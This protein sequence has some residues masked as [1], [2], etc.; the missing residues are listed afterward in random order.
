MQLKI[1][2]LVT[3]L[4]DLIKLQTISVDFCF[5]KSS[6]YTSTRT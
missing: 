3:D 2:S 4:F 1:S 5:N 6:Q